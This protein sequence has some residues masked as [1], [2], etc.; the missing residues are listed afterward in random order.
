MWSGLPKLLFVTVFAVNCVLWS[1]SRYG[2]IHSVRAVSAGRTSHFAKRGLLAHALSNTSDTI[3]TS[4]ND[5]DQ[6]YPL[7]FP[8]DQQCSH[9]YSECPGPRTFLSIPYL[10]SYFCSDLSVRPGLF[11]GYVLWLVFLFS[12]LGISASDF[13]CPNLGTLA[14]LLGLDENVAGVTFLAFGN[15]SPD[16]FATFSAMKSDSGSLAIGELLGAATF[17]TS[18]V[19]GSMCIIKPFKVNR[20]PFIRDVGFFTVAVTVLLVVLWD[21]KLEAWEAA[22]LIGLYVFYVAIVVIG[23]WWEKHQEQKRRYNALMRD[24]FREEE[25]VHVPYHDEEPYRDDIIQSPASGP[26]LSIPYARPRTASHPGPPRLGLY[27]DLPQRPR[28][29]SPSP[30]PAV[31]MPS[32]SLIGALEFRRVVS[33]LQE[34]AASSSLSLFESPMTPYP[35]GHYHHRHLPSSRSRTP[36]P[37]DEHLN[38]WDAS[39][40]VPLDDRSPRGLVHTLSHDSQDPPSI[41]VISHTPASPASDMETE[42]QR[43]HFVPPTRR[44]RITRAI[45]RTFHTLFPTLHHFRS[46]TFLGKVASILA[47]PAVM[48]LTLTLPVVVTEY[49]GVHS[50]EKPGNDRLIE[51]EE[52]GVERTLIAEEVVE[53]EMHEL[54]FNKWL[55]A[56]QCTLGP[57]FCVAILFDG[58]QHEPWLLLAAGISGLT[59]GILVAVFADKGTHPTAQLARCS[60]GFVVAVVW[61]MAIADEVVEVLQTIAFIFGL[62]DAIIGLTIFAVGNSLADLVANM[63][64][65]VFAPI[66]GFS[67]C[68]GGP[69]MNILLGVGISGSYIIRQT[70]EPYELHFSNTL[71]V[72]G[73]GL[74]ALL[75]ATLVFVPMNGYFL[76]R[77]WGI[78]LIIA[79]VCLM[80]ANVVVE[81]TT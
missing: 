23:T 12:T 77:G 15:G 10:R 2:K 80:I 7:A 50:S 19:V 60:M 70:A 11:A 21:S 37:A 18:C 48:A 62:S 16:V 28:T 32:F 30:Q 71:I 63:S 54:K 79:Y 5:D 66:M 76:P 3:F 69:M 72:T 74:L 31:H 20:F 44:Q 29:R 65:A 52:E 33:S 22:S 36:I 34:Q 42:S 57:L 59:I 43:S 56:V 81:I 61:I 17:I 8:V 35:G 58:T 24:E 67:A 49:E 51:F 6:C 27:T 4:L 26:T 53:E 75:L 40:G 41:P 13:F 1:N 73:T 38:P 55:M 25:V 78:T 9:V 46:K 64:V 47:A 39:L 68:F 45:A 14:Q